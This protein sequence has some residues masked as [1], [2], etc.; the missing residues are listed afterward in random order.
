MHDMNKTVLIVEDESDL[1][2]ALNSAL[3][4]EGFTVEHAADG[5]SGLAT[6]LDKKPDLILLDITMPK[7][8][9]LEVLRD[10][11]S[12]AWGKGVKVIVM[13]N[14]DD[15]GKIAEVL[16]AGGDE[17]VVKNDVSLGDIVNKVKAKMGI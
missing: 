2:E 15:M 14:H 8:D 6:A 3:S 9:G 7:K 17:Y 10:L 13:T 12:D 16:E 11:R 5:E 1:R 4:N